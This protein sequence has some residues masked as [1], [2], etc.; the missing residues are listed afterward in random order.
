MPNFKHRS[1]Q[2]EIMDDFWLSPDE[3]HP[4]LKELDVINRWLGGFSVYFD[5]FNQLKIDN[6]VNVADWGCGS[7]DTF[8]VLQKYFDKNAIR[9]QFVGVDAAPATLAYAAKQFENHQN[10]RFLLADVVNENFKEETF[11]IVISSLFTHHFDDKA[12]VKLIQKMMFSAKH[13][14]IINDLHR[15]PLAYYSIAMLTTLF[16]KSPMVKNDSK[17]SVLRGFKK[18]ELEQLLQ[19]A[20]AKNYRIKWMWAFRWQVII[21]K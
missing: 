15:H 21:Y 11:D 8:K 12:W 13:A 4:V 19:K 5:A 3:L 17:V 1:E 7:G 18:Q 10:V 14:V 20:G 16:S 9:P 6:E 2:Q